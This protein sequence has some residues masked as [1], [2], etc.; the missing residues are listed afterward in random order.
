[1]GNTVLLVAKKMLQTYIYICIWLFHVTY[2]SVHLINTLRCKV[3]VYTHM[4]RRVGETDDDI[5]ETLALTCSGCLMVDALFKNCWYCIRSL[6]PGGIQDL[7]TC[8]SILGTLSESFASN[9]Y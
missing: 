9:V 2:V 8:C 4:F 1:M 5:A 3:Y 7:S 6:R